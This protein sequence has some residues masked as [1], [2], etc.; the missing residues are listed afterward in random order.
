M[1]LDFTF[2][3][4]AFSIKHLILLMADFYQDLIEPDS[5]GKYKVDFFYNMMK[6]K[7]IKK[8]QSRFFIKF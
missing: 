4:R 2:I 6:K 8:I 1:Y 7:L 5:T 3:K